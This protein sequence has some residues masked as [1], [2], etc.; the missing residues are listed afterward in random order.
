MPPLLAAI[1]PAAIFG[2]FAFFM[3][4][5]LV[6]ALTLMVETKGKSLESISRDLAGRQAPGSR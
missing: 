2:S 3:V 4:L 5:Q 1:A 6:F